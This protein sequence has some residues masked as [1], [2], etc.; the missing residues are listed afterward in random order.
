MPSLNTIITD[1]SNRTSPAVLGTGILGASSKD[2]EKDLNGFYRVK[3]LGSAVTVGFDGD[4][5]VR[6]TKSSKADANGV[7]LWFEDAFS[8]VVTLNRQVPIALGGGYSGCLYSVYATGT[9]EFK[10]VHTARPGNAMSD[11]F[12]KG[13][14]D[15]AR[16]QRWTLVHEVPTVGAAGV[17]GCVTTFMVSRADYTVHPAAT[18]RTVRLRQNAQG[19]SVAQDVF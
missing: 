15:Y 7:V 3:E 4:G 18:V 13:L 17:A 8:T 5:S 16:D 14:R 11:D 19:R 12:V 6:V 9:G 1:L 10:C 2:F